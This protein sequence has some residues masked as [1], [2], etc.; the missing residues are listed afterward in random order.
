MTSNEDGI[1]EK[2]AVPE[3]L[4]LNVAVIP[5]KQ[6]LVLL[7]AS[8]LKTNKSLVFVNT[9]AEVNFLHEVLSHMDLPR[10]VK[11]TF[12]RLHGDMEQ[13]ERLENFT[14]FQKTDKG[15]KISAYFRCFG[16]CFQ[17]PYDLGFTIPKSCQ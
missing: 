7:V 11:R 13:A 2:F 9:M 5:P 4:S 1:Q 17:K 6:R 3:S 15:K 16:F 12:F 10:K 8:V 14:Q